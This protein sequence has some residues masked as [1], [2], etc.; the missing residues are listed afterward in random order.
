M[1]IQNNVARRKLQIR[2]C[3]QRQRLLLP[4][5]LSFNGVHHVETMI[6]LR[7]ACVILLSQSRLRCNHLHAC[8]DCVLSAHVSIDALGEFI[9]ISTSE[10]SLKRYL[11]F[12]ALQ[13][14]VGRITV[15]RRPM[16]LRKEPCASLYSHEC[17]LA[18]NAYLHNCRS[19][20][21]PLS[22]YACPP[23]QRSYD[24][25]SFVR[26]GHAY[27]IFR[28]VAFARVRG[29]SVTTAMRTA[30]ICAL[31]VKQV[32]RQQQGRIGSTL[33]L[34]TAMEGPRTLPTTATRRHTHAL[35]VPWSHHV[36]CKS[37]RLPSHP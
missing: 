10:H 30:V 20:L 15:A 25:H 33:T 1:S 29:R 2:R 21:P 22:Q 28:S 31:P 13:F 4:P 7:N 8:V 35:R 19:D 18:L 37:S 9:N 26:L 34:I 27:I 5:E 24:T 6:D 12:C 17:F 23:L 36:P 11:P 14:P 3:R 16:R 32:V